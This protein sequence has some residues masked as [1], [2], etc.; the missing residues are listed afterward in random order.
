M[1]EVKVYTEVRVVIVLRES[2]DNRT[3]ISGSSFFLL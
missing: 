1:L 3:E 2:Q